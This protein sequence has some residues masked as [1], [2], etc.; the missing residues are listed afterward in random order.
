MKKKGSLDALR[1]VRKQMKRNRGAWDRRCRSNACLSD[2][3]GS[4]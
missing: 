1:D 2:H 4:V 3:C